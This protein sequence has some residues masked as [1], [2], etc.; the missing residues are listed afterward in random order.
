MSRARLAKLAAIGTAAGFFSALFGVG[1]G[2]VIVPLL[3][4][5]FAYGEHEATGTSLAAIVVISALGVAAHGAY[6][7]VSI[8]KGLLVGL[9]AMGGVIFG[10]SLQQRLSSRAVSLLFACLLVAVALDLVVR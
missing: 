1:G 4:L 3:I 7:N 2:V 8:G 9:P 6:G 5:W 10:T